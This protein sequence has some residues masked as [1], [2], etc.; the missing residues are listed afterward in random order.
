M[1]ATFNVVRDGFRT[2]ETRSGSKTYRVLTMM[3]SQADGLE[4]QCEFFLQNGQDKGNLQW[5]QVEISVKRINVY[6]G[7]VNIRGDLV[8]V[9]S[10]NGEKSAVSE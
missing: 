7:V 10:Q 6:R 1:I 2:L 5:Q 4:N 8:K 3:D 9:I